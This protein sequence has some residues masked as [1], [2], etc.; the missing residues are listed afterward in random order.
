MD[1][2]GVNWFLLML[3]KWQL[4]ISICKVEVGIQWLLLDK[5]CELSPYTFYT[6][7]SHFIY[8]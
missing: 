8:S 3:G 5:I 2:L 7:L 4:I 6:N 1:R